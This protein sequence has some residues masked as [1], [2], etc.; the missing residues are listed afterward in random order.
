MLLA[1]PAASGQGEA[2]C[3]T[4]MQIGVQ[5][6]GHV[7]SAEGL[8]GSFGIALAVTLTVEGTCAMASDYFKTPRPG[9]RALD[10]LP[11]TP[12]KVGSARQSIG[13]P[14]QAKT[15]QLGA[16][17]AGISVRGNPSGGVA[18]R[19]RSFWARRSAL[20]HDDADRRAADRTRNLRRRLTAVERVGEA[21]DPRDSV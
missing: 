17:C 7:T 10:H 2:H 6:I 1:V 20:Q 9:R 11:T 18:G 3:S 15:C 12:K 5:R 19:A 4:T 14:R 21:Q 8:P 16:G 13:R